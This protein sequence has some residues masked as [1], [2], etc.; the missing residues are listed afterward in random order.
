MKWEDIPK[1]EQA[2]WERRKEWVRTVLASGRYDDFEEI[3]P[4][5]GTG[6]DDAPGDG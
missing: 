5:E 2:E 1:D 3:D 4:E 6:D